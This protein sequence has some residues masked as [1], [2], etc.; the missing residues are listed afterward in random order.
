MTNLQSLHGDTLANALHF[1]ICCES[2]RL[3]PPLPGQMEGVSEQIS[4]AI[5]STQKKKKPELSLNAPCWSTKHTDKKF[6]VETPNVF[7]VLVNTMCYISCGAHNGKQVLTDS[8]IRARE[9][10]QKLFLS[11]KVLSGEFQ[12]CVGEGKTWSVFYITTINWPALHTSKLSLSFMI[13]VI[14]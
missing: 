13:E 5:D 9:R 10:I 2:V 14:T 7:S 4:C 8:C 6:H 3:I 1:E 11:L 12:W